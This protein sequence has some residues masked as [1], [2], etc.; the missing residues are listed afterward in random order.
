MAALHRTAV[1]ESI[2][3][4]RTSKTLFHP[5][6]IPLLSVTDEPLQASIEDSNLVVRNGSAT[7]LFSEPVVL[8]GLKIRRRNKARAK[9]A[10][11]FG[12]VFM[13]R[14]VSS[15]RSPSSNGNYNAPHFN[16]AASPSSTVSRPSESSRDNSPIGRRSLQVR[17]KSSP[18]LTYSAVRG[19]G[20]ARSGAAGEAR[21]YHDPA[22]P[23]QGL[24]AAAAA[25]AADQKVDFKIVSPNLQEH[26]YARADS[27]RTYQ[28]FRHLLEKE[29]SR[30]FSGQ[31]G[32]E[33]T[34]ASESADAALGAIVDGRHLLKLLRE[35]DESNCT[36][37]GCGAENPDWVAIERNL[38][39]AL[40][41]C[42]NCSGVY[43]GKE[44]FAVRSFLYDVSLFQ[45]VTS[46]HYG[47]VAT[48][49]NLQ[50]CVRILDF[51]EHRGHIAVSSSA[52]LPA[53]ATSQSPG[54]VERRRMKGYAPFST[55]R[56]LF[57]SHLSIAASKAASQPS[58]APGVPLSPPHSPARRRSSVHV[59]NPATILR[60]VEG[61][62]VAS[63]GIATARRP[64]IGS[65]DGGE[66]SAGE[67][68]RSGA[69]ED[70]L[71][72]GTAGHRW[73]NLFTFK[74]KR[75]GGNAAGAELALPVAD[76]A[77]VGPDSS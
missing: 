29:R 17:P 75:D 73:R 14:R 32:S 53:L 61:V 52:S 56:S 2:S 27:L 18:N 25:V 55:S 45:D 38:L 72:A 15:S 59:T 12:G 30:V 76:V 48:A 65:V 63:G 4:Y 11:V 36:C 44:S 16:G 69:D 68:D 77:A 42:E 41:V 1:P 39:V 37:A 50:S 43:R 8:L 47:A 20:G 5:P 54:Q 24:T 60:D 40:I 66:F 58:L 33:L 9:F 10:S 62:A 19:R 71:R 6:T 13:N 57:P 70:Q 21:G 46:S 67:P 49:S 35:A 34:D 23:L 31:G 51:E 74:K 64:V 26:F 7:V 3:D 28:A 22:D